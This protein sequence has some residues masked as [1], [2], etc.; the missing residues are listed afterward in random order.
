M[1]ENI[2]ERCGIEFGRRDVLIKHLKRKTLCMPIEMDVDRNIQLERLSR[3]C[4][5]ECERC[6]K[7]YKNSNSLRMHKCIG[8]ENIMN[9]ELEK[10]NDRLD[11][12]EEEN[13]MLKNKLEKGDKK[14]I[15]SIKNITNNTDN[16]TNN[17]TIV[18][19]NS[20][21]KE[22]IDYLLKNPEKEIIKLLSREYSEFSE[23]GA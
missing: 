12:L 9:E 18:L 7:M 8:K 19:P 5:I 2:C 15:N 21:G 11:R 22:N 16:S 6:N 23:G 1:R 4:E 10:M 13:K 20:F 3:K 17:I 14:T